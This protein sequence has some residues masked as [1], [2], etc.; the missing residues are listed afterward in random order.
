MALEE[1]EFFLKVFGERIAEL[2]KS[3]NLSYRKL[4]QRCNVD[5]S[6]ISKI[7]KGQIKIQ[8]PTILELAKGLDVRPKDLFDFD[9]PIDAIKK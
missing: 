3:K 1:A 4:A 7:E 2:R 8:L 5:Y 9:F 6:D